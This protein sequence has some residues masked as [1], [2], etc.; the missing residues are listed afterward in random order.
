MES[1]AKSIEEVVEEIMRT[2]RSLLARPG[3]DE[4]EA[5][6][7]LILNVDKEEQARI[8]AIARK[9]KGF[10]SYGIAGSIPSG[11]A[12]APQILDSSLKIPSTSGEFGSFFT[13]GFVHTLL[14]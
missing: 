14:S 8:V 4:V 2:H 13:M 7:T 9:R 1:S 11:D 3:I 10:Y 6:K 12:L 5:A